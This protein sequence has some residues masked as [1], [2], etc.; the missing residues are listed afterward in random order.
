[1]NKHEWLLAEGRKVV[2]PYIDE[3]SIDRNGR[4]AL[5]FVIGGYWSV[6]IKW[7]SEGAIE[8]PEELA[9]IVK[10]TYRK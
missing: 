9:L 10:S 1:M 7:V 8:S 3:E 2:K 5:A 6:L 4:Y